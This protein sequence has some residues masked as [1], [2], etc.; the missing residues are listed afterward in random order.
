MACVAADGMMCYEQN[1]RC[2][3]IKPSLDYRQRC[4][5]LV[6][7]RILGSV[8]VL[9]N[10]FLCCVGILRVA[11]SRQVLFGLVFYVDL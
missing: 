7:F 4:K 11:L 10:H 5:L 8:C 2:W 6:A 3:R 9:F 1:A